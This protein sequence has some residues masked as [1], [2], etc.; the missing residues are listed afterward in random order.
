MMDA[1][2]RRCLL[3]GHTRFGKTALHALAGL[4]EFDSILTDDAPD[5]AAR[6]AMDAAGI[7]LTIA[8][9]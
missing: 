4:A 6:A 1:A 5:S 8:G 9:A 3:I 7:P 2:E